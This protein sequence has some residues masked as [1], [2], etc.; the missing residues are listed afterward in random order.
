MDTHLPTTAPM[1]SAEEVAELM[2]SPLNNPALARIPKPK[3]KPAPSPIR[4]YDVGGGRML[5]ISE[6]AAEAGICVS[7]AAYRVKSGRTGAELLASRWER[8]Q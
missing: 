5:K 2:R 3:R 6:I 1:Y 4:R 7:T 8:A